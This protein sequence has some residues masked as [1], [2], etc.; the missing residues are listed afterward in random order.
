MESLRIGMFA[1]ESL[2]S[3]RVGG[4]APHVS[5][6]SESLVKAGHE[7]HVFTRIGGCSSYDE[8]N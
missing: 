5:E 3:I 4:V 2:H 8:I 6:L 7:V 1:W